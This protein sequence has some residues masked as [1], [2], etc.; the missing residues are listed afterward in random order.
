MHP[1]TS[2]LPL[3]SATA[4]VAACVSLASAF[5]PG[6]DYGVY[7]TTNLYNCTGHVLSSNVTVPNAADTL[8][9]LDHGSGWEQWTL[10]MHGTF[11]MILR[12]TQGDPSSSG[13]VSSGKFELLIIGVNGT[14]VNGSDY[15]Q[16]SYENYDNYRRISVGGNSLTWDSTALW[17]NATVSIDGYSMELDSYSATR[18]TFHP[19]V[20]F[21]NGLLDQ[22]GGWYGSVPLVR[23]HTVGTLKT[24]DKQSLSLDGLTVMRHMFSENALPTYINK[25]S[26]GTAWGY[27]TAFYDTHVFYQT[28]ATNGSVHQA[29]YLGRAMPT[30]G[31]SGVFSSA[32]AT[33][34]IT[35]DFTLYNLT[36]NP[37]AQQIDASLPEFTDRGGG[38]TSYYA[39]TGSTTAPFNGTSVKGML[40]GIFEEY[41]A[42]SKGDN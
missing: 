26:A 19:N 18:N 33:Y 3:L 17:Y 14:T 10:F 24:P 1:S 23:G 6:S 11:P 29:A 31:L 41:Q 22:T 42:P 40:Q 9:Q 36:V 28:E 27:S 38:K 25:Y 7:K 5:Q 8:P 13:S 15:G 35:D 37:V 4:V 32:W 16:L 34:A 20:G 30:P 21:Y 2:L 39:I 12:W